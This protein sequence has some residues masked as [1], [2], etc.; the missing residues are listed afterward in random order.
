MKLDY[1]LWT[2]RTA[3]L[4]AFSFFL[5]QHERVPVWLAPHESLLLRRI[6]EQNEGICYLDTAAAAT[7]GG[8]SAL[9][10]RH[11]QTFL[12]EH[13]RDAVGHDTQIVLIGEAT[14]GTQEFYQIR[15]EITKFLLEQQDDD[16][17]DAVLLEADF[18]ACWAVNRFVG[19]EGRTDAVKTS[20]ITS[21]TTT[22]AVREA[23]SGFQDR[24]PKWMW[25]NKV[26]VDFVDWLAEHNN[27]IRK[28]Q[29]SSSRLPV[30][31]IGLDI[32][33]LFQSI[34]SV[35]A[36]LEN[37]HE[38][39]F[40]DIVRDQYS[41]LDSFRPDANKYAEAFFQG[42]VP[43]QESNVVRALQLLQRN[44]QKLL[45]QSPE[46]S[47][48]YFAALQ[49]AR[50]VVAVEAYYRALMQASLE[51]KDSRTLW[52]IREHAMFNTL[53]S[54]LQWIHQ[55]KKTPARVIVWAHNSHVGDMRAI[56]N[57]DIYQCNLGQMCR[58]KFGKNRVYSIG[59][60]CNKGNVRAAHEWG[61]AD[62]IMELLPAV[63]GS[64]EYLL[65]KLAEKTQ[66]NAVGYTFRS[67]AISV[68]VDDAAR[69]L[70]SMPRIQRSI[71]LAYVP[72]RE[73]QSHYHVSNL[74]EEFDFFIHVD[75][76]HAVE[77]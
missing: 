6:Q 26:T 76:S 3:F 21:T 18:P 56:S 44:K 52:N 71:G 13:I 63:E 57:K 12:L 72:E 17:F 69:K 75:Q 10:K 19:G 36:Y 8:G 27:K 70:F 50:V 32:Y 65:S 64:H 20:A 35:V 55:K 60:S 59:F 11:K 73:L 30:L 40:A 74:S 5:S 38:N 77:I 53:Q 29:F 7:G 68:N 47:Q 61:E 16:G 33:S 23:M 14:H 39:R 66:C 41:I 58:Q 9:E 28:D 43:S 49:N 31:F 42:M 48:A 24:F 22:S 54:S 62:E 46:S 45:R 34:D 51:G 37:I 25:L 1:Y 15:S 67:N 4:S 2:R